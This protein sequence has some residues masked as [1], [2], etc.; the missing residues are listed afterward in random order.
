MSERRGGRVRSG[1]GRSYLGVSCVAVTSLRRDTRCRPRRAVLPTRLC[2]VLLTLIASACAGGSAVAAPKKA[3]WGPV[4]HAGQSQFPIYKSLGV[5]LFQYTVDWRAT[6]PTQPER[7]SDPD[8][9]A[10]VWSPELDLVAAEAQ[11]HGIG[12]LV[13]VMWTPEWANGGNPA[14]VPPRD[15][16][17]YAAFLEALARRYPRVRHF[18]VWGEPIRSPNY[19]VHGG[20]APNYYVKPN[21]P[22]SKNLPR[23]SAVQR[24]DARGYAELVDATYARLKRLNRRNLVIGGNTTTSGDV[25]PFN[26]AKYLRLKNGKPPRMDLFGHN[27]FG[28]RG[29]NLAKNQILAGTAD[30]SDL[31]VFAPWV[32]RWISRD[33]RN[34]RLRLFA[35]EYTAP[36]DVPSYEFPYFVTRALQ[37]RWVT[38]AFRVARQVDLYGLGWLGLRDLPVRPDGKESRTGLIDARGRRKPAYYAFMRE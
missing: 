4:T 11:R 2:A 14:N 28:T 29:P 5:D 12:V 31:D 7:P 19:A 10:Y 34:R 13:M 8:D 20:N 24:A 23:F 26:W 36:T 30:M 33:G 18:M 16:D 21:E 32:R 1:K 37:A 9:P 38:A 27:P 17:A 22:P 35:S 25:D 15:P 3:I 6:A